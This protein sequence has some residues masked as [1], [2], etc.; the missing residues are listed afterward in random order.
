M[1]LTIQYQ[2]QTFQFE[3][4]SNE[5]VH[6]IDAFLCNHYNLEGALFDWFAYYEMPNLLNLKLLRKLE[7]FKTLT[8]NGVTNT[9]V[10]VSLDINNVQTFFQELSKSGRE[11]GDEA[12]SK[13]RK[14]MQIVK[15]IL[16]LPFLI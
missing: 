5:L 3:F 6:N 12:L 2:Y 14:E 9:D 7:R 16:Q 13:L 10:L 8:E 15:L 4:D 1:Y 11:S